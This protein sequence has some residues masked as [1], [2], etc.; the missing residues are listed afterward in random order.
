MDKRTQLMCFLTVSRHAFHL[1]VMG[2]MT[3]TSISTQSRIFVAWSIFLATV[4]ESIDLT[5]LPGEVAEFLPK[6]FNDAG[7]ADTSCMGDCTETQIAASENF[8][9]NN[10]TFS[11]H[12]NH[13]TEKT[14]VWITPMDHFFSAVT[15]IL[16]LFQI[17]I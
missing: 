13:T 10:V 3:N 4:F 15:H 14:S 7:F 9:V 12:K 2:W 11:Q 16:A 8:D 6:D 17:L 5:P 1:G